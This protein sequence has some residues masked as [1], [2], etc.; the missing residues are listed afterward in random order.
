MPDPTPIKPAKMPDGHEA[1]PN[2]PRRAADLAALGLAPLV[3]LSDWP[4]IL[5]CSI[6][7]VG[8]MR[9]AGKLPRPDLVIGRMPRWRPATV[10][11]WIDEQAASK[12]VR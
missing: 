1:A 9:V 3:K 7:T 12:G 11:R 4:V 2:D 5:G 8:R 6:E 10:R